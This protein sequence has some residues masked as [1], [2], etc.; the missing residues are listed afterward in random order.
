VLQILFQAEVGGLPLEQVVAACAEGVP[1]DGDRAG[2]RRT[3]DEDDWRFV[4]RLSR[5]AW[6]G[7][8]EAD[9]MI[10]RY[11]EGWAVDRMARV[12]ICVLR[13]AVHELLHTDTP[14]S[15]TINEAVELAKRY[16]TEESGRFVNGILGRIY[17][18]HVEPRVVSG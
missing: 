5:G 13:M 3:W 16:S 10:A 8:F 9:A 11:A 18:E 15:V 17:R 7:R 2:E 1:D 14:H 4:V 12:D 6:E